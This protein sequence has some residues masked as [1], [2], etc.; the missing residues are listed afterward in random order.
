MVI[1]ASFLFLLFHNKE[2][3][4]KKNKKEENEI[5]MTKISIKTIHF[6]LLFC[7]VADNQSKPSYNPSPVVAQQACM[8]HCL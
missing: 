2:R 4:T 8:Y 6:Y 7:K 1:I 3:L 5:R